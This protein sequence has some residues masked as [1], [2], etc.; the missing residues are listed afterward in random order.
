MS[1]VVHVDDRESAGPVVGLLNESPDFQVTTARLKLGDYLV[2]GRLLFE[3]KTLPDLVISIITG[4]L[5]TQALKLAATSFRPAII[6][7]GTSGDLSTSG[8][9][10]ESI[11]GAL[12]TV[13]LFCGIPLLRTRTPEETVS[14]M[15]FAAQQGQ[16]YATE[17]LPRHGYRPRGKRARQL[18]ILQ[19]LP[20]IGPERA[21]KLLAR[22]GS[23]AAVM[24][25]SSEDLQSTRGIGRSR[26]DKL[27]WAI[28]EPSC[29]Y[30]CPRPSSRG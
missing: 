22:F 6:L 28:E 13:T 29:V 7:E 21:R 5:F 20:G 30:S 18:F 23:V 2:D 10:W 16:A 15:R 9:R 12:V 8:M 19:G 1:F 25:A 3:R 24:N 17:S 26:A 14:T 11:Q 27:R 4:R